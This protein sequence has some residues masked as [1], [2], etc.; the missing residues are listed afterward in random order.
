[1]PESIHA[2]D[3]K[4]IR[5]AGFR[6][7]TRPPEGSAIWLLKKQQYSQ[8]QALRIALEYDKLHGQEEPE[9]AKSRKGK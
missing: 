9:P 2:E 4:L 5:A 3:D 1:M 8:L 6:L 7:Y